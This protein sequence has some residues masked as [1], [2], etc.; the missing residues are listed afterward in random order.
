MKILSIGY[1]LPSKKVGNEELIQEILDK[2]RDHFSAEEIDAVESKMRRFFKMSGTQTRFHRNIGERALDFAVKAG[3]EAMKKAGVSPEDIDLLI[4]AGVGRGWVEPATANLFQSELGLKS[5]TCFDVLDACAS[6]IR[7]MSIARS[8]LAQKMYKL[9]MIVNCEFNFRE[10]ANFD[11]ANDQEL[12]NSFSA[13]TIG[14]AATATIVAPEE[15][16]DDSLFDFKTWGEKHGLCKIPLPNAADFSPNGERLKPM[17]FFTAPAELLT[18]TIRKLVTH[19]KETQAVAEKFHDIIIGH[20][21]S[22][23]STIKAVTLM[24][25]DTAKV[26]ET[27]A[28]FGNTVSASL[29]LALAVAEA[30]G[31]LERGMQVLLL[32]GSA[33]VTTALGSFRY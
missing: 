26:F 19:F 32:M 3:K 14:E 23:P 31:K 20:A 29:P 2:N 7:S 30:E 4:Y 8:F 28:R 5:A 10:Y 16:T 27:H 33:G 17:S 6:W 24:G 11:I 21:V 13:F 25:M 15:G 18:F 12:E 9:V 22:V 1:A